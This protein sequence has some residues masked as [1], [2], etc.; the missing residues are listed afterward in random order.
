[1]AALS[2]VKING[3]IAVPAAPRMT[4]AN[5]VRGKQEKPIRALIYGVAGVGKSTFGACAPDPIFLCSED[6][7][8]HL[9]IAR[10]PSPRAWADVLEATRILATEKHEYKTLVIDSIDWLEPLCWAQVCATGGK[11]SIEDFGF[12]KGYVMAVELW[13]Q[14]LSRLEVLERACKMNVILVAHALVKKHDDPMTGAFDR[15]RVKLHEKSADLLRE[16]V[17]AVLFARHESVGVTDKAT[18]KVRGMSSGARLIHTQ[19]HAAFDAK[20]RYD[21]PE[22]MPLDWAGFAAAVQAGAPALLAELRAELAELLP[23]LTAPRRAHAETV[24][25]TWA[26]DDAARL[27]Q[28]LDK[29]RGELAIAGQTAPSEPVI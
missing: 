10:L 9:D 12:G 18:G 25:D 23:R 19:W 16:W 22:I 26:G 20:N 14:L 4:L 1:M 24:R 6:G 2:G 29:V 17:D 15:Y 27:A 5:V 11:H 8:A 7:T 13:R 3:A 28:L 21:L